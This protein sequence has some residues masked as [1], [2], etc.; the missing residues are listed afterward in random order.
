[1]HADFTNDCNI[2]NMPVS[3][4]EFEAVFPKLVDDLK[5]HAA[6]YKLP[7]QA[8]QWFDKVRLHLCH[9]VSTIR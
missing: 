7:Y 3:R 2:A 6:T 5:E 1:M 8:M 4:Q 9:A